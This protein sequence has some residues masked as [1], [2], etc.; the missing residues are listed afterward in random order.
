MS[1]VRLSPLSGFVLIAAAWTRPACGAEVAFEPRVA[2]VADVV[3]SDDGRMT[4]LGRVEVEFAPGT[5]GSGERTIPWP[6]AR[7]PSKLVLDVSGARDESGDAMPVRLVATVTVPGAEPV[8]TTRNLTLREGSSEI[9]DVYALDRARLV[10]TLHGERRQV[11]VVRAAPAVGEPVAMRLEVLRVVGEREISLE[12]NDLSSLV[13]QSV[14]YL[15]DFS[16]P[17]HPESVRLELTPVRI[18]G[19]IVEIRIEISG[20]LPTGGAP[21]VVNRTQN[22][23]TSRGATSAV[24]VTAGS[25][26][27]GYR[28]RVTPRF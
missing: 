17:G 3:L 8:S 25:P 19:E 23:V 15:L 7:A 5:G 27:A 6:S 24:A 22:L 20:T 1:S 11:P 28:F 21:L 13:G 2:V 18:A 14:E 12:T 10:L 4:P 9:V 26:P 16:E